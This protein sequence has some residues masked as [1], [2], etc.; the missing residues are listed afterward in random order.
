N[1]IYHN[2][3]IENKLYNGFDSQYNNS[4]DYG[5]PTGGNYWSDY[6]GV[7]EDGDGIGD[8]PYYIPG[9]YGIISQD[10]YPLMNP[11]T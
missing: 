7:D 1:R 4:W 11:W 2:N 8:T 9:A 3:L 10:N 5:Y 6:T